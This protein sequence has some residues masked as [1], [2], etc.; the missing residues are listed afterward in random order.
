[1]PPCYISRAT[2]APH[3]DLGFVFLVFLEPVSVSATS[4]MSMF[5][6]VGV[7]GACQRL[8]GGA[9]KSLEELGGS[10]RSSEELGGAWR[11]L[12]ELGRAWRSLEELGGVWK[13]LEELTYSENKHTSQWH[14]IV[15]RRRQVPKKP[16][17]P[18]ARRSETPTGS[19]QTKKNKK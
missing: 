13:S 2:V 11:S 15:A 14:N 6:F 10:W 4:L 16:N 5:G 1:M 3:F 9:W 18:N 8:R 19:K 7:F 17:K 12:E